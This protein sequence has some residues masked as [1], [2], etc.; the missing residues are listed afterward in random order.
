M[1]VPLYHHMYVPP[2][3]SHVHTPI[4]SRLAFD[5][6]SG[7]KLTDTSEGACDGRPKPKLRCLENFRS[8]LESGPAV[9]E[10]MESSDAFRSSSA[11]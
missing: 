3:S 11:F 1:Y 4:S 8:F 2:I 10:A 5:A 7:A 6:L 9:D